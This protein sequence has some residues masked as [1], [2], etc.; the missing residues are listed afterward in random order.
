MVVPR[1]RKGKGKMNKAPKYVVIIDHKA[2]HDEQY[3]YVALKADN[4][5]AA[6]V[7]A[8][9]VAMKKKEVYCWVVSKI[10]K[11]KSFGG[12]YNGEWRCYTE[13]AVEDIKRNESWQDKLI[14]NSYFDNI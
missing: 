6:L 14:L 8:T 11:A 12:Y 1:Q 2:N 13:G 4:M 9:V 3:S 10:K 5:K 7:E